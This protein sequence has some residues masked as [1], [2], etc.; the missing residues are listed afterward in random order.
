MKVHKGSLLK[1]VMIIT[2]HCCR[3]LGTTGGIG[4]EIKISWKSMSNT[5]SVVDIVLQQTRNLKQY[6][7]I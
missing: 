5:Q 3:V 1:Y 7:N 2:S 4:V 6:E